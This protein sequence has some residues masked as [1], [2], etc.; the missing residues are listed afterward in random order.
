MNVGSHQWPKK[1]NSDRRRSLVTSK[2]HQMTRKG[3]QW[4]PLKVVSDPWRSTSDFWRSSVTCCSGRRCW[5]RCSQK[6]LSRDCVLPGMRWCPKTL[7]YVPRTHSQLTVGQWVTGQFSNGSDGSWFTKCDPLIIAEKSKDI[8]R[9]TSVC[10]TVERAWGFHG[11]LM[12]MMSQ[13][14]LLT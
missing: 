11:A 5:L 6:S 10:R 9:V 12:T 4:P 2:G 7:I 14:P 8:Q 3:H 1:I 13:E